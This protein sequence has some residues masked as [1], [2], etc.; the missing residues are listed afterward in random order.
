MFYY[1]RLIV[2]IIEVLKKKVVFRRGKS[3]MVLEINDLYIFILG[4]VRGK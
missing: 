2:I 4:V 1:Y 3:E